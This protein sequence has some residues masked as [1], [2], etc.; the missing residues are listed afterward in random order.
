MCLGSANSCEWCVCN[1]ASRTCFTILAILSYDAACMCRGIT[2][3]VVLLIYYSAPLTTVKEVLVSRSSASLYW[4][5]CMMNVLNGLLWVGYGRVS[6]AVLWNAWTCSYYQPA[7]ARRNMDGLLCWVT[8]YKPNGQYH[9]TAEQ[10]NHTRPAESIVTSPYGVLFFLLIAVWPVGDWQNWQARLICLYA[11]CLQI[12][13][14]DIIHWLVLHMHA[15][16]GCLLGQRTRSIASEG[17]L[18]IPS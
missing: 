8:G 1:G 7:C 18:I 10:E 13:H 11:L 14:T 12:M 3:N 17:I 5:L 6:N 4:P 9:C 15:Q 16:L 2:A